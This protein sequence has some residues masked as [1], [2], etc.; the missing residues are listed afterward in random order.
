MTSPKYNFPIVKVRYEL[1]LDGMTSVG[2]VEVPQDEWDSMDDSERE[3][4]VRTAAVASRVRFRW[5]AEKRGRGGRP[6]GPKGPY[7]CDASVN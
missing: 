7:R 3:E 2:R 4:F 1:T 6:D 5:A